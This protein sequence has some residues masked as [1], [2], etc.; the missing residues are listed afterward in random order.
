MTVYRPESSE[1]KVK[2]RFSLNIWKSNDSTHSDGT[3]PVLTLSPYHLII[4]K[5]DNFGIIIFPKDR[6]S[7]DSRSSGTANSANPPNLHLYRYKKEIIL[8]KASALWFSALVT[9]LLAQPLMIHQQWAGRWT[10]SSHP[11]Q[12]H[13]L[14]AARRDLSGKM[15][16]CGTLHTHPF[17]PR[18]LKKRSVQTTIRWKSV[19]F[20]A[21][22][23]TE[24][25]YRQIEQR[26]S[27]WKAWSKHDCLA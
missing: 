4:S 7:F 5:T 18:L 12:S 15:S 8:H 14:L 10:R 1:L 27:E 6:Y 25:G 23:K 13:K 3:Y 22:N 17:V 19:T 26:P 24:V 16:P 2:C 11:A 20:L 9:K 21:K